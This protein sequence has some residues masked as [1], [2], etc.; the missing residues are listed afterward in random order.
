[1]APTIPELLPMY[2]TKV[3]RGTQTSMSPNRT[4]MGGSMHSISVKLAVVFPTMATI[5]SGLNRQTA[6]VIAS[7]ANGNLYLS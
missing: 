4:K 1:M 6:T 2:F 7:M 3:S 5:L